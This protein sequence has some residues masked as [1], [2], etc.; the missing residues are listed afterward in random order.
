MW[1][2]DQ[3]HA[4]PEYPAHCPIGR[5]HNPCNFTEMQF[6]SKTPMGQNR[7]SRATRKILYGRA[8]R[9]VQSGRAEIA[10]I[11]HD[12]SSRNCAAALQDRHAEPRRTDVYLENTLK[13]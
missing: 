12:G 2:S 6:F 8:Y 13:N 3:Y 1:M 9:S 4:V 11:I 10:H 7:R 5:Q